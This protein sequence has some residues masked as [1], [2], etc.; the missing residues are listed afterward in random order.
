M[1]APTFPPIRR[2][3][4]GHTPSGKATVV[5]DTSVPARMTAQ[6]SSSLFTDLYRTDVFPCTNDG[7][8][9]DA[10]VEH[11]DELFAP[12]GTSFRAVDVPP[13]GGS[14]RALSSPSPEQA[15]REMYLCNS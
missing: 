1:S 10:A 6:S 7:P 12:H 5:A 4:T 8:F 3:V 2:I 9:V 11:S 14:V 13:R 15:K